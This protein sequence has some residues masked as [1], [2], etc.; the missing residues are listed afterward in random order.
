[1][2][3]NYFKV[4]FRYLTKHP[5]YSS[6]NIGGLAIGLAIAFL[7]VLYIQFELSYDEFH[8][9]AD[10]LYRVSVISRKQG[11]APSE[12]PEFTPPIG[13]AMK[14]E[15]AEVENYARLSTPRP[16]Y[17]SHNEQAFK[18]DGIA[19]ADSTLFDLFSFTLLEG[20]SRSALAQPFSIVLTR[21]IAIRIFGETNPVG[22]I[23]KLDNGNI[24]IVTGII[25]PPPPNSHLRFEA[26]ISFS[27]L[28]RL[29]NLFLDWDGGNQYVTYVL[30]AANA[31]PEAVQQKF[32]DLMWRHI[33]KQLSGI[34]VSYEPYLQPVRDIHLR[35][36]PESESVRIN[37]SVM[38]AISILILFIACVNFVN[39]ATAQSL[40]RSKEVGIRKVLGA[41]R[42]SLVKKFLGESFVLSGVA[43]IASLLLLEILSGV[44][45][46]VTGRT[47]IFVSQMRVSTAAILVGISFLVAFAS[48]LYPALSL[49]SMEAARTLKGGTATF[50]K[51][52]RNILL[53]LQFAIS[54][55]FG[56][57]TMVIGSQLR[58][59][60][61][62]DLGYRKDNM[63]VLPLI[64]DEA[65]SRYEALKAALSRLPGVVSV[66]GSSDVPHDGFTSNGYFPEGSSTPMMIHVVD[67]DAAFLSTYGI[68]IARGRGF[69]GRS[70]AEKD[71]YLINETLA[72][73]LNWDN[74]IGK[75]I[76]RNGDH[77]VIGV[78]KDFHYATLHDRIEP[79]IF[80]NR[81]WLDQYADLT[82][83]VQSHDLHRTLSSFNEAW[84]QVVP[85]SPFNY[86]FLDD[87]VDR[88]YKR[89]EQFQTMLGWSSLLAIVVASSGLLSLVALSVRQRTK[90][91]G[92]RKVLGATVPGIIA[93]ISREYLKLI[94]AA[95][96]VAWPVAAYLMSVWL[97]DFAYRMDLPWWTFLLAG[98]AALAAALVAII[99]QSLKAAIA[100]PVDA[101][102][103][104]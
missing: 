83:S 29:P 49:S 1:M 23:V 28:Y 76:R 93:L 64:G 52:S 30:L 36:N 43:V 60:K 100:N 58:F 18:V 91:I 41:T 65:R 82:V 54:I 4:A 35:Y 55:G 99:I 13:P 101:L 16:A 8:E 32:P 24:Y 94:V 31:G 26:L 69:S 90:E 78:V 104:E 87:A 97:Q 14:S 2:F 42:S 85:S 12:T 3:S 40:S 15:F 81:P 6:I 86:F 96:V 11:S 102:R 95:N 67:V 66:A 21:E 9:K 80:T 5:L 34:G 70:A 27:T 63:V 37:L 75:T 89:E 77:E 79:L 22:Q 19:F 25:Q 68:D 51:T 7:I 46:E 53:I 61:S 39:L 44:F 50:K 47:S 33:N 71:A 38:G 10:R 17:I 98:S 56:I 62:K 73:E 48:G 20:D 59:V 72:R 84:K 103:Y 88:V 74:P 45:N 57:S 92:I